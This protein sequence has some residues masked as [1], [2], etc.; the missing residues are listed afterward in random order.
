MR[1]AIL[2]RHASAGEGD[3]D[4]LRA[5][6]P[7]GVSEAEESAR[8]L[9]ALR[10]PFVPTR[11]L[12]STA[13]RASAT[14]A[15]LQRALPGLRGVDYCAELYLGSAEQLLA[16]LRRVADEDACVLVV[17]HEPGLS[18]LV[19]LLARGAS[20]EARARFGAGMRPAAFAAVQLDVR[21]WADVS[22]GC[23]WL[24]DFRRP[25]T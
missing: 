9:A 3:A 2:L 23:A 12:C 7:A 14:L 20:P 24:V 11:A 21:R 22:P 16:A 4:A 13:L 1:H 18:G 6:T 5:L 15:S 8:A 19:R 10:A 17:A 25:A